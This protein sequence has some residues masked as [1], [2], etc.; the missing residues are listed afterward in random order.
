MDIRG[1]KLSGSYTATELVGWYNGHPHYRDC[2]FDLSGK[3][4]VIVGNGKVALDVPRIL[5]KTPAIWFTPTS[6]RMHSTHWHRA[7]SPISTL[8]A[9]L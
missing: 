7:A 1:E 2:A 6:P 9:E 8:S 3:V 5:V 4:A